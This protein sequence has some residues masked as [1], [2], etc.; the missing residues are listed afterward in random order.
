MSSQSA[1]TPSLS[2]K[3]QFKLNLNQVRENPQEFGDKYIRS[4]N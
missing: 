1:K 4:P 3:Q 2:T